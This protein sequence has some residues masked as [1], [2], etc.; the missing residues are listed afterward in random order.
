MGNHKRHKSHKSTAVC[1]VLCL[2]CLLWFHPADARSPRH[3]TGITSDVAA[4]FEASGA[5]DLGTLNKIGRYATWED[6]L[7]NLVLYPMMPDTNAGTGSTVYGLFRLTGNDMTLVNGPTWQSDGIDLSIASAYAKVTIAGFESISD[8]CVFTRLAPDF[9][10]APDVFY[11]RWS[12]GDIGVGQYI[13]STT[14]TGSISGETY[15]TLNNAGRTGSTTASWSAGEDFTEVCEFGT[16]GSGANVYKNK[17][18]FSMDLSTGSQVFTPSSTGWTGD[19]DVYLTA[20]QN[21]GVPGA[22]QTGVYKAFGVCNT[23]LTTA[24]RETI[25]DL[26]NAL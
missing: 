13:G 5:R 16:F 21:G 17:T 10:S 9:A 19:D 20:I 25:T 15:T 6:L 3:R 24:Q 12:F 7:D 23:S 14:G 18:A 22:N 1:M 8:G 26:I 11:L 4:H 2:L